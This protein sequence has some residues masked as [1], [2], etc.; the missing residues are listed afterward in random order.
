[1]AFE[2][3]GEGLD[4][5]IVNGDGTDSGRK[6][7]SAIQASKNYD[8][9][10]S[11]EELVEDGRAEVAGG[12]REVICQYFRNNIIY[13]RRGE[14]RETVDIFRTPTRATLVMLLMLLE[15][16]VCNTVEDEEERC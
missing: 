1:M 8:L 7:V 12:L 16:F 6:A 13:G 2:G 15:I 4:G 10:A 3:V 9:E 11:F 14:L 5:V